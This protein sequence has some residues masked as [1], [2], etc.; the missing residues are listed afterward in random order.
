MLKQ[1]LATFSEKPYYWVILILGFS[2]GVPS[3]L[4]SS[5][6]SIW[7]RDAGISYE[8]IG[9]FTWIGLIY[10][11][12]WVWAPMLDQ[13]RL[14]WLYRFGRRRSWLILSQSLIFLGLLGIAFTNPQEHLS[15]F[16]LCACAVAFFSA[17]QDIAIDGY[18]LE[19][20]GQ[21]QQAALAAFY[22][23]GFRVALL[24]AGS[25]A[26][27]IATYMGTSFHNYYYLAWRVTY[28]LFAVLMIPAIMIS[29][30]IAEPNINIQQRTAPES[31]FSFVRQLI[32][33]VLVL[34]LVISAPVMIT[35]LLDQAWPRALLYALI[36]AT[37][38]SPWGRSQILPVR[39]LLRRMRHHLKLAA[40]AKEIPHFDFVHQGISIIV[41]LIILVSLYAATKA[42]W[43]AA[44]PRG[45][46]YLLIFSGCISAPGRY[47]MAPILTPMV[48]FAQRYRWRALLIIG[49]ISTFKLSDTMASGM[50]EIFLLDN[51]FSTNVVAVIPRGFGILLTIIGA[52]GCVYFI[53]RFKVLPVLFV[54]SIA[55]AVTNLLYLLL[56]KYQGVP[57]VGSSIWSQLVHFDGHLWTLVFIVVVDNLSAGAATSA[58]L[59]YL[60]GLT[61]L[62]FSAS[63]YAML[64]SLMLLL[65][66]FLAGYSGQIVQ[67]TD[68]RVFFLVCALLGLPCIALTLLAWL[69]KTE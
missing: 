35:A 20:A 58:L 67:Y 62:K 19:I 32:S 59:A 21:D 48:E 57:F 47:L 2:S 63:Q 68:Y 8:V 53:S 14:P 56:L 34:F 45:I 26:L 38:L 69:K 64:S 60:S 41:M 36:L 66:R 9:Y 7:L 1:M 25:G 4:I 33:V 46:L 61:N 11:L 27:L 42:F 24:A 49:I 43:Y 54:C 16:I 39:I 31:E 30:L 37:C 51:G 65:P 15:I 55:C 3:L 52:I 5:T 17:T 50:V 29:C 18:R 12:K 44:W 10:G 28:V 13:W 23:T 22:I 6:L 40:S